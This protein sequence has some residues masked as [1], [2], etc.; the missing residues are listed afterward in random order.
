MQ[1]RGYKDNNFFIVSKCLIQWK[2]HFLNDLNQC[3]CSEKELPFSLFHALVCTILLHS[4]YHYSPY[5]FPRAA[6]VQQT[7]WLSTTEIYCLIEARGP[8]SRCWQGNLKMLGAVSVLNSC[9]SVR[10]LYCHNWYIQTLPFFIHITNQAKPLPAA[11]MVTHEHKLYLAIC[12]IG[13]R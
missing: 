4:L 7:G 6:V 5:R 13:M 12:T 11:E 3:W 10:Y 2:I 1:I 8:K 9:G